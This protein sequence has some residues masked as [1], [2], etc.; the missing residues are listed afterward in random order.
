MTFAWRT[1][2][3]APRDVEILEQRARALAGGAGGD[4]G[5]AGRVRLVQFRLAGG[6]CGVEAAAVERAV[7]RLAGAVAVPM[8]DGTER[9]VAFVDERPV[10]VADLAGALA[11]ARR[12]ASELSGAPALVVGSPQGSVAVAVDGPLELAEA[13]VAAAAAEASGSPDAPR[14]LGRLADGTVLLDP[15]WL[16]AWAGRAVA[17]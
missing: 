14:L 2:R 13:A 16:A 3:L 4:E 1:P 12:R 11:G 17:P 6:A 7:S 9:A 5:E 8:A 10:P 15:A